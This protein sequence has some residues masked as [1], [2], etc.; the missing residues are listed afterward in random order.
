MSYTT[1]SL[2]I[3]AENMPDVRRA[4]SKLELTVLIDH[5]LK[6]DLVR[7]NAEETMSEE[8]LKGIYDLARLRAEEDGFTR[9]KH[10]FREWTQ[11]LIDEF[12]FC[13]LVV[14]SFHW[15]EAGMLFPDRYPHTWVYMSHPPMIIH[16]RLSL[17]SYTYVSEHSVRA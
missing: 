3:G 6:F 12:A 1:D 14:E 16:Q 15:S 13:G 2:R 10:N 4:D 9:Y 17:E 11:R 8:E 5:S 7:H